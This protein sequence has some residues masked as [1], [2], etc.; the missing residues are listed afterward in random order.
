MRG[1]TNRSQ[2]RRNGL[3]VG[4]PRVGIGDGMDK[5]A[6]PCA[7]RGIVVPV[8][9]DENAAWDLRGG[10]VDTQHGASVRRSYPGES[11]LGEAEL[12]RIV[13][14]HLD[15]RIGHVASEFR[16]EAGAGHCVP[17][18]AHPPGVQKEGKVGIRWLGQN[19]LLDGN[20]TG[21]RRGREEAPARERSFCP[22]RTADGGRPLHRRESIVIGVA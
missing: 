12:R 22:A 2:R 20:E 21:P 3:R 14:V 9:R 19:R 10:D 16:R 11:I 8:N 1:E 6:H 5:R 18:V 7:P 17:L 15:E 4:L 13:R